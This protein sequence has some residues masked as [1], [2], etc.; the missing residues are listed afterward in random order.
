M[1]AFGTGN[2][3]PQP[4]RAKTGLWHDRSIAAQEH[5]EFRVLVAAQLLMRRLDMEYGEGASE[6]FFGEKP[7]GKNLFCR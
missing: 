7:C 5:H 4:S 6:T 2:M 1:N 3:G